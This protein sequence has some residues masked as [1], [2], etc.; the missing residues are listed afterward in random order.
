MGRG[1]MRQRSILAAISTVVALA[2]FAPAAHAAVTEM[3]AR[4]STGASSTLGTDCTPANLIQLDVE[5][6]GFTGAVDIEFRPN[7]HAAWQKAVVGMTLSLTYTFNDP[8]H[9]RFYVTSRSAGSVS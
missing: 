4:A 1:K 3:D 2:F 5:G 8:G 6:A 7:S 9:Y